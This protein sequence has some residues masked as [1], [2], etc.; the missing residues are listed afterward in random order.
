MS[1]LHF[2][3]DGALGQRRVGARLGASRHD[4]A[5]VG[6]RALR[7]ALQLAAHHQAKEHSVV[8]RSEKEVGHMLPS[9]E[10]EIETRRRWESI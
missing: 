4:G 9:K 1:G 7:T 5:A 3:P 6:G 10:E 2:F 8:M